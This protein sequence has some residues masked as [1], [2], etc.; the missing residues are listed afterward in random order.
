LQ[1]Q[2]AAVTNCSC[3]RQTAAIDRNCNEEQKQPAIAQAAVI[4]YRSSHQPIEVLTYSSSNQGQKRL[5]HNWQ[6]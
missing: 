6:Q 5:R 2:L 1:L 3:D 4:N